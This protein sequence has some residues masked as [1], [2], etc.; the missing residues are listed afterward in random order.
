MWE[1]KGARHWCNCCEGVGAG[2][3]R[4][5]RRPRA[6]AETHFDAQTPPAAGLHGLLTAFHP[7]QGEKT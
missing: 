5:G 1:A 7:A 6:R 4:L 3:I 2:F